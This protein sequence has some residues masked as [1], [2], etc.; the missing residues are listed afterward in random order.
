[1]FSEILSHT[2]SVRSV[3]EFGTNIG[4]NLQAIKQILPD[5]ELSAIEINRQAVTELE[6]LTNIKVYN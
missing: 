5:V 1:M 2:V 4:F 3:I 6:R